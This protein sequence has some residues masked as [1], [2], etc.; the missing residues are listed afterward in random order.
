[1]NE[2]EREIVAWL[3][4]DADR[5]SPR[6]DA[7]YLIE[8]LA[9]RIEAGEHKNAGGRCGLSADPSGVSV[10]MGNATGDP[11]AHTRGEHRQHSPAKD[12]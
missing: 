2:T 8:K 5:R 9:N 12:D 4:R 6:T 3:R 1:M 10:T 11:L 7:K